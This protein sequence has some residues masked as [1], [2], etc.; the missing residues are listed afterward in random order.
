LDL[1]ELLQTQFWEHGWNVGPASSADGTVWVV[2]VERQA[3]N[4]LLAASEEFFEKKERSK[5][6]ERGLDTERDR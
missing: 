3:G 6:E 2:V 5:S 1:R 4:K